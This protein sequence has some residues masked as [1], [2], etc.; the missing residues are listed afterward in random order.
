MFVG[1]V[2]KYQEVVLSAEQQSKALDRVEDRLY[3]QSLS[4]L[5]AVPEASNYDDDENWKVSDG[6]ISSEEIEAAG[7]NEKLARRRKR[8][9]LDARR[10]SSDVPYYIRSAEKVVDAINKRKETRSGGEGGQT[11]QVYIGN[12]NVNYAEQEVEED[13]ER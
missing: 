1:E 9:A 11:I 5:E 2:A 3:R 13:D 10:A 12:V 7:G 4:V 6:T 8:V